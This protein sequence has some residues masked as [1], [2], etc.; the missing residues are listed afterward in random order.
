M[1]LL[2][3]ALL[4]ALAIRALVRTPQLPSDKTIDPVKPK[5]PPGS[6]K[7]HPIYVEGVYGNSPNDKQFRAVMRQLG[8][9]AK[10]FRAG[11]YKI[12]CPEGFSKMN[13]REF[14]IAGK[15]FDIF[16]CFEGGH[17]KLTIKVKDGHGSFDRVIVWDPTGKVILHHAPL[18]P[19]NFLVYLDM[20]S[21]LGQSSGEAFSHRQRPM[22]FIVRLETENG[23]ECYGI[24]FLDDMIYTG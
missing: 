21:T 13:I 3:A 2:L 4:L 10:S 11:A 16:L 19:F 22:R 12:F 8:A 17:V 23:W 24:T 15:L 9:E 18:R 6:S 7:D 1:S 20:G 5:W 14:T